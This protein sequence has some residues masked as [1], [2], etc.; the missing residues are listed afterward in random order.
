MRVLAF[1]K[2]LFMF[3]MIG[4]IAEFERENLLERQRE[5]I[6]IAKSKGVYKG[7]R[8][9]E[10]KD[11]EEQYRRYMNREITKKEL[12]E[13]LKVSRPTLDRMIKEHLDKKNNTIQG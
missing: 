6:A 3:S 11:F 2:R 1:R 4:A 5:G 9:K 12:A 8:K 10:A 7:R 13:I